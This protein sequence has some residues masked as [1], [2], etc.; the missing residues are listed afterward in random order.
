MEITPVQANT[1]W[2]GKSAPNSNSHFHGGPMSLHQGPRE[3]L[4][5]ATGF[6]SHFTLVSW[7]DYRLLLQSRYCT[8]LTSTSRGEQSRIRARLPSPGPASSWECAAPE[9]LGLASIPLPQCASGTQVMQETQPGLRAD[10]KHF[11]P[12]CSPL[13]WP[14]FTHTSL[15]TSEQFTPYHEKKTKQTHCCHHATAAAL[16]G[17]ATAT[18]HGAASQR[19]PATPI[20]SPA[21]TRTSLSPTFCS[22]LLLLLLSPWK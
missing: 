9:Q 22:L 10:A 6:C 21:A 12:S 5:V 3:V 1:S 16:K 19:A 18:A 13:L 8:A 17:D 15:T 11:L 2:F 7:P 20:S 14:Q 4:F